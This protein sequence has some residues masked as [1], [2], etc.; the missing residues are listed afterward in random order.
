L[1]RTVRAW[2]VETQL[3]SRRNALIASTA[4]TQLRRERDDVED[5]LDARAPHSAPAPAA[6]AGRRDVI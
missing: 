5:F 2:P 3:G 4:L 6:L 1:F